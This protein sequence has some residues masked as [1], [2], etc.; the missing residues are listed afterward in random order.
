MSVWYF[1]QNHSQVLHETMFSFL[2]G[3][4]FPITTLAGDINTVLAPA[5]NPAGVPDAI[6]LLSVF[7]EWITQR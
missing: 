4:Q 5:A 6:E 7:L 3:F 1:Q 2:Q